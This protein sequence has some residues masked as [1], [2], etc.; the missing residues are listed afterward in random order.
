LR[1]SEQIGSQLRDTLRG[2]APISENRAAESRDHQVERE[3]VSIVCSLRAG[4]RK[5]HRLRSML[6]AG[7]GRAHLER[8]VVAWLFA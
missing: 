3:R 5:P 6:Q 7:A 2:C 8:A 1:T 4:D